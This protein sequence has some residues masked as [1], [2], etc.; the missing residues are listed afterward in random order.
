M[1]SRRG[2]KLWIELFYSANVW[3]KELHINLLSIISFQLERDCCLLSTYWK[4]G[5]ILGTF[6][7]TGIKQSLSSRRG[8]SQNWVHWCLCWSQPVLNWK[9]RERAC[10]PYSASSKFHTRIPTISVFLVKSLFLSAQP[11]CP[12]GLVSEE[13]PKSARGSVRISPSTQTLRFRC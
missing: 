2:S 3:E 11:L 12:K 6:Y 7:T 8:V 10:L 5:S 1:K 13:F 4:P 9:S